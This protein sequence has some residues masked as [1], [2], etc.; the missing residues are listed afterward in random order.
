VDAATQSALDAHSGV[1]TPDYEIVIVGAGLAGLAMAVALL[2]AGIDAFVVLERAS[3]IGG[4]WRDNTSPGVA[5]DIPSHAYQF[6]YFRKPDWS[7]TYPRGEEVKS[8]IDELADRYGLRPQIRLN[9][10]VT[11]RCWGED[12]HCWELTRI[13]RTA[14]RPRLGIPRAE[15]RHRHGV[16][17]LARIAGTSATTTS[18]P[19]KSTGTS[20]PRTL[21]WGPEPSRSAGSKRATTT[22]SRSTARHAHADQRSDGPRLD[23]RRRLLDHHPVLGGAARAGG[24]SGLPRSSGNLPRRRDSAFRAGPA[25]ARRLTVFAFWD[26]MMD[27]DA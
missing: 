14:R 4:V 26:A 13:H 19:T 8:Y 25:N 23:G 17:D 16:A 22:S 15:H 1:P 6:D 18:S 12:R 2:E 5:V 11:R 7:R 9:S 10:H 21:T 3:D 20:V 24:D 27:V